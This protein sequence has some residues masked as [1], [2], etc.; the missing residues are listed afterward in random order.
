MVVAKGQRGRSKSRRPKRDSKTSSSFACYFCKK[1]GHIKKNHM[2]Y[3]EMLKR[4]GGKDSDGTST[5]EKS[6]Q[7]GLSNK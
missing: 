1:A 6:N 7:V 5:S 2:K 3:K 4:K